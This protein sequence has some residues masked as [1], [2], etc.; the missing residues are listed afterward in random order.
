MDAWVNNFLAKI[1]ASTNGILEVDLGNG[2]TIKAQIEDD[3][4]QFFVSNASL[5]SRVGKETFKNFLF[6]IHQNRDE[7]AF[8]LLLAKMDADDLIAALKQEAGEMDQYNTMM[9]KFI[10]QAKQFLINASL[11]LASKALLAL[12]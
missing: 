4:K 5:L 3:L 1:T 6:L 7:D 11:R 9:E 2:Q 8:M 12:L 10:D